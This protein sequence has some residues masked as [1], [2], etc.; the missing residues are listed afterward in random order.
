M[1]ATDAMIPM[2]DGIAH[3]LASNK[4]RVPGNQRSYAW[5]EEQVGDLLADL[6]KAFEADAEV[7]YLG[8][9]YLRSVREEALDIVDGQQRLT[10][11]A[12]MM[13]AIRDYF[14]SNGN[15]DK[16]RRFHTKYLV[17]M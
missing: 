2:L 16:A 1:S 15:K 13:C 12:V 4:L 14:F 3:V 5:G 8:P 9:I 17:L 10:T 6:G 11:L 7:Y